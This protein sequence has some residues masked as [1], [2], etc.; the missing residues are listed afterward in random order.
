MTTELEFSEVFKLLHAI[1]EGDESKKGSLDKIL[2]DFKTTETAESFL[3]ELGQTFLCVGVEE[4]FKYTNSDDFKF[5]GQLSKEEWDVFS[6]EKNG[7]LPVHLAN[8]MINY[9]KDNKMGE[10]LILKWDKSKGE[11]EKHVMPMARYIT[12]GL[13]D[14]LE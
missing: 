2:S 10:S 7:D 14:V 12:E 1:K 6:K 8:T 9:F 11:I 3:H 4:I 13:I 5:I